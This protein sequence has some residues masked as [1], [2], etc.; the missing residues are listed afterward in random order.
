MRTS[1]L[2]GIVLWKQ[3]LARRPRGTHLN[4]PGENLG[5]PI[6]L[7][8]PGPLGEVAS[9]RGGRPSVGIGIGIEPGGAG[10]P[11][12]VALRPGGSSQEA[13]EPEVPAW[14]SL[15]EWGQGLVQA[16]RSQ[17][18]SH[19]VLGLSMEE[20][21]AKIGLYFGGLSQAGVISLPDRRGCLSLFKARLTA[22]AG[23]AG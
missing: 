6:S 20:L 21:E 10:S 9:G 5:I 4:N 18:P 1:A 14:Q 2:S 19:C 12:L 16:L 23:A 15:A 3:G 17:T 8:G 22:R 13:G 7:K 11:A